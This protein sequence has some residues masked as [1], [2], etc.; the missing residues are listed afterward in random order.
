MIWLDGPDD[1]DLTGGCFS[2]GAGVRKEMAAAATAAS[3]FG[4]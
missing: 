4:K 1:P 2:G 3:F